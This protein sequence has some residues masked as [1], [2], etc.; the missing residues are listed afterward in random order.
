MLRP[1]ARWVVLRRYRR[2]SQRANQRG[3]F[4][5]RDGGDGSAPA[6]LRWLRERDRLLEDCGQADVDAWLAGDRADRYIAR[7]FAR[8][9]MAQ[10]LMPRLDFP[11]G[12]RGG[13]SPPVITAGLKELAQRLL[14]EPKL[15]ACDRVAI[16]LIAVFAQPVSRVA[17]L[18]ADDV[19]IDGQNVTVRLGDTALSM[20]EPVAN[21]VRALLTDIAAQPSAT[22]RHPPWLFPGGTSARPIGEQ[23]LSGRLKR[24]GVDCNDARRAALLQ[25]A[26]QL[27][28]A[29]VADL[30]GVHVSTATQWAQIAG[31]PWGH[32]PAMRSR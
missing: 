4:E 6:F 26:G 5:P 19:A 30:L 28:A 3:N 23:V 13:S 18:T 24:I 32:Y 15:S 27:P 12:H 9:A 2:K 7:S 16:V 8:W 17:H 25:L 21:D 22:V 1:F 14:H 11:A 10:K 20:P 31:R 29:I